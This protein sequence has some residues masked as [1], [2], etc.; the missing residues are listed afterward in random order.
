MKNVLNTIEWNAGSLRDCTVHNISLDVVI[1]CCAFSTL[2][3]VGFYNL[4]D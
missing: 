1:T 4:F 3:Y 2:Q